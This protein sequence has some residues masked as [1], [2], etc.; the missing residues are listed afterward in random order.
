MSK[1]IKLY[2]IF[3]HTLSAEQFTDA[4]ERFGVSE[5]VVFSKALLKLWSNIPA[6]EEKIKPYLAP[7]WEHLKD[8]TKDDY[9]LVQ[10]DF[11]ATYIV[12]EWVKSQ[13]ATAI[14]ATTERN[15]VE[16]MVE[17][18]SIKTSIFSHV[19]YRIYGK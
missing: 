11:G 16:K 18:K 19:R 7:L 8:I 6:D 1:T 3:S 13:G 5:V 4:H 10:G 15:T 2:T 12:V 14:Y 9:I 17:G